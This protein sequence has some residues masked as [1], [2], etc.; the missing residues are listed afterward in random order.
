M[1]RDLDSYGIWPLTITIDR[2]NGVYSGGKILAIN[3]EEFPQEVFSGDIECHE[4]W[5]DLGNRNLIGVG[6]SIDEAIMDLK[7]KIG[8]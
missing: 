6:D 8:E 1:T 7:K 5:V 2:Y 3:N 4:F